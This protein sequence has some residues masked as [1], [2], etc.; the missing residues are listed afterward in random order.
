VSKTTL[1]MLLRALK[2]PAFVAHHEEV[3]RQAERGGWTF[4]TYLG[5]LAELELGER[6]ARKIQR[7]QKDSELPSE[8]TLATL[9]CE[10][11]PPKV[12]RQLPALCEGGFVD[13]AEN[14]LAF[15]LPGRGKTHLLCA[16]GHELVRRGRSVL[17]APTYKLVQ[18]LLLAKK[19]LLLEDELKALDRFDVV[20]LDDIGYVQQ[21]QEE[22]EVL[23]TFL[24]E[25]YERRS[26]AITSNLVFSQWDRIFMNPM[27]TAAAIDRVVHHALILEL[28]GKSKR[29]DDAASRDG[30]PQD[31]RLPAQ[32]QPEVS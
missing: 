5:H 25:R 30:P 17:F 32:P 28:T 27:T 2:L 14:L 9:D 31:L 6:K 4:E 21:D 20:I 10:R 12:K 3:A 13:R 18:R 26:V 19:A 1:G 23:F 11:L 29:A 8:K 22:M 24:A 15:G 7:L 16:V